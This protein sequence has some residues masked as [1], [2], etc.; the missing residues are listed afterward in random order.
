[1]GGAHPLVL[2]GAACALS[3]GNPAEPRWAAAERLPAQ[4]VHHAAL[5][6]DA[7]G[8][9]LACPHCSSCPFLPP[10]RP[11]QNEPPE[12]HAESSLYGGGD[13]SSL[14]GS[15]G[16][17]SAAQPASL[18]PPSGQLSAQPPRQLTE[19]LSAARRAPDQRQLGYVVVTR[20]LRQGRMRLA[21]E[22]VLNM[23]MDPTPADSESSQVSR[24]GGG[25]AAAGAPGGPA[26]GAPALDP[27]SPAALLGLGSD[28]DT[29]DISSVG[30]RASSSSNLRCASTLMRTTASYGHLADVA[31]AAAGGSAP[32][33]LLLA[34]DNAINM[35]VGGGTGGSPSWL[36]APGLRVSGRS[37]RDLPTVQ[38]L[39]WPGGMPMRHTAPISI[40]ARLLPASP[41][42]PPAPPPQP[43]THTRTPPPQPP[44]H[45]T[46]HTH[47]LPSPTQ[48]THGAST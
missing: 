12:E 47:P 14:C 8:L 21:L 11:G 4:V 23:T 38:T 3:P 6:A 22:E 5:A 34:E 29:A 9:L 30:S 36:L 13:G 46:P 19:Q 37:V 16:D 7:L 20:P 44:P 43:P 39:A 33:R 26:P 31:A 32:M 25:G 24:G 42:P 28:S 27:Y 48:S 17:P 2:R 41:R 18:P 35:K 15:G 45:P 1:M 10:C 40:A